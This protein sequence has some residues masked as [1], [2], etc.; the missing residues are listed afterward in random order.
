MKKPKAPVIQESVA[1]KSLRA[2]GNAMA[3]EA[4]SIT[5]RLG[6]R[7]SKA[8]MAD[9]TDIGTSAA[10]AVTA[11]ATSNALR[12][13]GNTDA[14]VNAILGGN[15]A[16]S[17]AVTNARAGS[18]MQRLNNMNVVAKRGLGVTGGV[19]QSLSNQADGQS[20]AAEITANSKMQRQAAKM[21]AIGNGISA[22]A[23]YG[24]NKQMMAELNGV[25]TTAQAGDFSPNP[26][27]WQA[28]TWG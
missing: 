25:N 4:A 9:T 24:T 27:K 21:S 17:T 16:K 18:F 19:V 20:R 8:A 23:T 11:R 10:S 12:T 2:N 3:T 22:A 5:D 13:A 26:N 7:A 6:G 15:S 14:K 28:P 1:E